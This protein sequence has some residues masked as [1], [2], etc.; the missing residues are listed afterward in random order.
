MV[1]GEITLNFYRVETK[2]RIQNSI[3]DKLIKIF[4]NKTKVVRLMLSQ[5][6]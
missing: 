2:N 1:T 4:I 6:I 5:A 3:E